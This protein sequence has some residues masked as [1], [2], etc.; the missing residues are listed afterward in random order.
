MTMLRSLFHLLKL[1]PSASRDSTADLYLIGS[2]RN[3]TLADISGD[4]VAGSMENVGL[5]SAAGVKEFCG[6]GFER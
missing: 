5:Y 4:C 2:Q 3:L 1:D 6:E